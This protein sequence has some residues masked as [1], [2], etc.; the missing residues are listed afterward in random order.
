MPTSTTT[1]KKPSTSKWLVD[2]PSFPT[3]LINIDKLDHPDKPV[4]EYICSVLRNGF[5]TLDKT[6]NITTKE[7]KN[8][9][10]ARLQEHIV[11]ELIEKEE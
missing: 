2:Y 3:T 9:L 5:D 4:V 7:C 1:S 11:T 6:N 8:N 10:S